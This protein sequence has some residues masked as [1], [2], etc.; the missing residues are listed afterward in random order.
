MSA[1]EFVSRIQ[2]ELLKFNNN[3]TTQLIQLKILTQNICE[4]F[5]II[6]KGIQRH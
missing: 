4:W 6:W 1:K 5:V 2:T 3:K